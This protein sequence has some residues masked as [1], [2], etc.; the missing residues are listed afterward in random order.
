MDIVHSQ[1]LDLAEELEGAIGNRGG[2]I[3]SEIHNVF[4][5]PSNSTGAEDMLVIW[6]L[7]VVGPTGT[8]FCRLGFASEGVVTTDVIGGYLVVDSIIGVESTVCAGRSSLWENVSE[9]L[10]AV[11]DSIIDVK[12]GVGTWIAGGFC[13]ISRG[14]LLAGAIGTTGDGGTTKG[15]VS[16]GVSVDG[17]VGVNDKTL[18]NEMDD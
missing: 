11:V 18:T 10:V 6:L 3:D 16:G 14:K 7:A 15:S 12:G 4:G 5:P 8:F 9:V 17:M 2:V 1:L 13:L